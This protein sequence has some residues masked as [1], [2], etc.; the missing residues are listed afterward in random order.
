MKLRDR[1]IHLDEDLEDF[2]ANVKPPITKENYSEILRRS[3]RT[4][5][6]ITDSLQSNDDDEDDNENESNEN[7]DS[8][9]AIL[10]TISD[11]TENE[12]ENDKLVNFVTT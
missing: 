2:M 11:D 10:A 6:E 12:D 9:E 3:E 7:E 4:N 8:D 5:S 1:S